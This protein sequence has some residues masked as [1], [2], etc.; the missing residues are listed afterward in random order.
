MSQINLNKRPCT[1]QYVFPAP[2]DERLSSCRIKCQW[3]LALTF[4]SLSSLF[5]QTLHLSIWAA[6]KYLSI[7]K[8]STHYKHARKFGILSSS[9]LHLA[10]CVAVRPAAVLQWQL[11]RW[12]SCILSPRAGKTAKGD[13]CPH[14]SLLLYLQLQL[15]W[16]SRTLSGHH[17]NIKL[18]KQD[19]QQTFGLSLPFIVLQDFVSC[20][21]HVLFHNLYVPSTSEFW[22]LLLGLFCHLS[23]LKG[24]TTTTLT[25]SCRV[26]W[27][28]TPWR[29][30]SWHWARCPAPEGPGAVNGVEMSYSF[31][32]SFIQWFMFTY[33]YLST[34]S[35]MIIY[36]IYKASTYIVQK[37]YT[38]KHSNASKSCPIEATPALAPLSKAVGSN[39]PVMEWSSCIKRL[40]FAVAQISQ[41]RMRNEEVAAFFSSF[42]LPLLLEG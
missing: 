9:P 34:Y 30:P 20:I 7:C 28:F 29:P 11:Y 3:D 12:S 32:N 36:N 1:Q 17:W 38:S 42:E 35:V 4:P 15:L 2:A 37:L 40:P 23:Q 10:C 39:L 22:L 19:F 5:C 16:I 31:F 27:G 25:E 8:W 26:E 21:F 18:N 24:L 14:R 6:T 41:A 33:I 13:L